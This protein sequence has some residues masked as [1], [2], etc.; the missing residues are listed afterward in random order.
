MVQPVEEPEPLTSIIF[1]KKAKK[2]AQETSI[3]KAL[4]QSVQG[5]KDKSRA[6]VYELHSWQK[7]GYIDA[8]YNAKIMYDELEKLMP[9][10]FGYNAFRKHYYIDF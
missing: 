1:T 6:F 7:E 8:H 2:E 3:I 5:R 10:P 9:I 4:Q